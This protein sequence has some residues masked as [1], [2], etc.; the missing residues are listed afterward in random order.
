MTFG[1]LLLAFILVPVLELMLLIRI[2]DMIGVLP[3]V[4]LV[5]LTGFLGAGM[6]R[7]QGMRALARFRSEL[8]QGRLPEQAA[9]DGI[10]VLAGGILLLTPGILTDALGFAL[11]FPASRRWILRR[12][13]RKLEQGIER[14]SIRVMTTGGGFGFGATS[15]FGWSHTRDAG[16]EVGR[17]VRGPGGRSVHGDTPDL[18]PRHGIEV[19]PDDE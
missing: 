2:G 3:T 12:L 10:S 6:A 19:P 8:A 15:G 5:L 13:R 14:G 4:G 1:R 17:R 16:E 18:D 7:A 9:L 11:L